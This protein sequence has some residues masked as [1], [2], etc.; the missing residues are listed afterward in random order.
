MTPNSE[1]PS[2]QAESQPKDLLLLAYTNRAVDEICDMLERTD[3]A[4]C[5]LRIGQELSCAE[6]F[7]SRLLNTQAHD[8]PTRSAIRQKLLRTPIIVGT[9]ASISALR[10]LFLIKQFDAAIIDEASQ[11]LEP[12]MLPLW[13]AVGPEGN[14]AIGK[15]IQT[16]ARRGHTGR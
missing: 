2:E 1:H 4:E 12:Q 6:P 13:C 7:R 15:F 10:E 5:Y 3:Y 9:L 11:V 14:P 16:T 8:Y